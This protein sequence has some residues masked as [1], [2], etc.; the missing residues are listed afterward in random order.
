P[1]P[2]ARP[3]SNNC[4]RCGQPGHLSNTCPQR[5]AAHLT[6]NE[7][8]TENET[9]EENHGYDEHEQTTE[10]IAGGDEVTGEDRG[11]FLVVRQLLYTP[12]MEL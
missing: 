9:T 8:G 7:G 4:Y 3:R 2:Y 5:P 12:R 10:E 11:E 6:I 1:N